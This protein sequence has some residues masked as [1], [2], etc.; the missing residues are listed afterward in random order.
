MVVPTE[1]W[2]S[3]KRVLVILAHPDDPE[4]FCG[5]TL[6]RWSREGNE[7][8]YCL[9]TNGNKGS[10]DPTIKPKILAELREKEQEKAAAIIGVKAIHQLGYDDGTLIPDLK[11]RKDVIRVIRMVKPNIVVTCDP[12]NFFP[13]EGYINHPDHRA[14]GQIAIDAVFPAAGNGMFF[15][16]LISDEG[17]QPHPVEEVWLSLSSQPNVTFDVTNFY[18]IKL[19]ALNEHKSQ[20][21]EPEAFNKRMRTARHTEDS[22]D[23][24][25]RY[26]ESFRRIIFRK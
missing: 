25:P 19:T 11:V 26:E 2:E 10:N 5:A 21:G 7:I 3:K 15:P 23:E 4:F 8:Q 16:E 6:A 24:S 14:A 12:T 17:L 22:T 9:I 13:N 20:I 18:E 1:G